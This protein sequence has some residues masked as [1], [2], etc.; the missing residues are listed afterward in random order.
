VLNLYAG[1]PNAFTG[2]ER[3]MLTQLGEI[4]GHAIAAAE[5]KQALMSD[6]LVE[7]EF[8]VRDVF[9][10]LGSRVTTEEKITF[11]HMLAIGDGE[12][13]VYGSTVPDAMES[14]RDLVDS[15]PFWE[16]VTVRSEGET[17]YFELR[18]TESPVLSVVASQGGYIVDSVI[19]DGDLGLTVH[20]APTVGVRQVIDTVKDQYPEARMVR[21]R[22]IT[23]DRDEL[24]PSSRQFVSE[25]TDR[26]R[27]ALEAAYYAGYFEWPRDASGEQVAD[28]LSVSPPT[29]HQHL[30]KA[31]RKV[32]EAVFS[33]SV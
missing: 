4:V 15:I 17:T 22:Q 29:F 25:L 8:Q 7:L 19:E 32:F 18:L 31:Q 20:L 3:T 5:R 6:E 26:Q 14:I 28:S 12:F 27:S 33:A 2:R 24:H 13:L 9:S 30:R 11:E 21:R 16:S 1:R 23:R 10:A